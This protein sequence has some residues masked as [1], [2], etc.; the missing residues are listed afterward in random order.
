M[1]DRDHLPGDRPAVVASMMQSHSGL[2]RAPRS[3]P[4]LI[5]A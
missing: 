2:I 1:A 3:G 4:V 5:S